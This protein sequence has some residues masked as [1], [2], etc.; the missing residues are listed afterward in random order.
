M[1]LATTSRELDYS[2]KMDIKTTFDMIPPTEAFPKKF[3]SELIPEYELVRNR[4]S[5]HE[6]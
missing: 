1:E 2:H 3:A 5:T 4:A 6:V